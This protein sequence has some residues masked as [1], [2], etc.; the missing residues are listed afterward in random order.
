MSGHHQ[1]PNRNLTEREGDLFDD[2]C[3]NQFP[4]LS[5]TSTKLPLTG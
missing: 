5:M 2:V 3:I 4:A 1:V